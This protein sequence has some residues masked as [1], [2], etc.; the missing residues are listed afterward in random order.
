MRPL[1]LS[2]LAGLGSCAAVERDG[3]T[4][5]ARIRIDA[6]REAS[7]MAVSRQNPDLL[8]LANDS[9]SSATLFVCN[10]EGQ[11]RGTLSIDKAKNVD[12][13]DLASF[14]LEGTAYLMIADTGDN[15]ASREE[16]AL[17]FVAEPKLPTDGS[18]L[19]SQ[20]TPEWSIRFRYEDGPRDCEAVAVDEAAG[21][22]LLISKRDKTPRIYELP[23]QRPSSDEVL[24]AK[25]VGDL[26]ALP[27]PPTS[28]FHPFASQPTSLDIAT[29]GSLAVILGY[30]GAY[31]F[32]RRP[33]EGWNAAFAR[34]PKI[35]ADHKLTQ[36]EALALS[37]DG[38][39]LFITSEGRHPR[40][41]AVPMN[42][43]PAK[44]E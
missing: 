1:L 6:L 36:A 9:G 21:R 15:G 20:A 33:G 16:V 25:R 38:R 32:P 22:I 11:Q 41:L 35:L 24:T 10:A 2:I 8:W 29:D 3:E 40:L 44:E 23:L 28:R 14:K 4:E 18:P 37:P 43:S 42:D 5:P 27:L 30:R 7:G 13:E 39:T 12:W 34:A 19:D 31:A 26:A 17:H